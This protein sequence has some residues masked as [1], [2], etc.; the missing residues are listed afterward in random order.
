[1]DYAIEF[2][3]MED[4]FQRLEVANVGFNQS[5]VGIRNVLLNVRSLDRRIVEVVEVIDDCDSPVAF[6]HQT[7]DEVR[8]NE[9]RAAG[10][11]NASH[12]SFQ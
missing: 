5:E 4:F 7:I 2:S 11:E 1:M 3:F 12:F 10:D 8:T 9:A 6:S